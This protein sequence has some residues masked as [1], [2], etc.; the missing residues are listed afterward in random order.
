MNWYTQHHETRNFTHAR[1][2][3]ESITVV[4]KLPSRIHTNNRPAVEEPNLN[5]LQN[6]FMSV[7]QPFP[8]SNKKLG[9]LPD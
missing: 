6:L 4:D 3:L 2:I 8:L 9:N 1:I 5:E 7:L